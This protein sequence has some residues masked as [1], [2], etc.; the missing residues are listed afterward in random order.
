MNPQ[1]SRA[2]L[3]VAVAHIIIELSNNYLP[4]LY[5]RLMPVMGLNYTQVGVAS[6][7]LMGLGWWPGG[8]GASFTGYIADRFSLQAALG[9]LV[10]APV[11]GLV[12]L[13]AYGF[14]LRFAVPA[15]NVVCSSCTV[16]VSAE[17]Y[18][19]SM[20]SITCRA[21]SAVAALGTPI[22]TQSTSC[23]TSS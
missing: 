17:R 5:P 13:L 4:I 10:L 20:M 22:C 2:L 11:I 23:I 7:L 14:S 12:C 9:T 3:L 1:F 16:P 18:P 21:C 8:L 19:A 6:G 15:Q